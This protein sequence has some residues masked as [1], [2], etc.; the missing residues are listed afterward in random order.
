MPAMIQSVAAADAAPHTAVRSMPARSM[1]SEGPLRWLALHSLQQISR[2]V[3]HLREHARPVQRDSL[4]LRRCFKLR[5]DGITSAPEPLT[6][7][8]IPHG[9]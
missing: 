2:G 3:F 9:S 1:I 4:I 6:A 7:I 5:S 8:S